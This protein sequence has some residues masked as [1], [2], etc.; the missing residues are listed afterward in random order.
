[1]AALEPIWRIKPE[2]ATRI[3]GRIESVLDCAS[4]RGWRPGENSA[5]W[6]GHVANTLPTW[7]KVQKVQHHPALSWQN[8]GAFVHSLKALDRI[9]ARALQFTVLTAA[10]ACEVV[11][12]AWEEIDTGRNLDCARRTHEGGARTPSPSFCSGS[13]C[14]ESCFTTH[15]FCIFQRVDIVALHMNDGGEGANV[16]DLHPKTRKSTLDYREFDRRLSTRLSA[17]S[18]RRPIEMLPMPLEPLLSIQIAPGRRKAKLV[19]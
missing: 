5:R 6:R 10:R 3:R 11:G 1:M 19:G 9:G 16:A 7:G 8:I 18:R 12:A 15:R 17:A 2:T 14:L 4:S 13:R